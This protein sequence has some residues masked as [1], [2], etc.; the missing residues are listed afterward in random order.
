MNTTRLL[1]L[2]LLA[3]AL[4]TSP[5]LGLG[6]EPPVELSGVE[7]GAAT[8]SVRVI[9]PA[10][11]LESGVPDE[12]VAAEVMRVLPAGGVTTGERG[13]LLTRDKMVGMRYRLDRQA[14][15]SGVVGND[16]GDTSFDLFWPF[17]ANGDDRFM[18]LDLRT[19]VNDQGRGGASAG[20]G[21][22]SYN[23][24]LDRIFGLSGWWDWDN[25]HHRTYRQAGVSFE[26]LGQ[27]FDFRVNGYFPLTTE[28]HTVYDSTDFSNPYFGGFNILVDRTRVF[29]SNYRGVDAEV[30]GPLPVLGR[31]GAR[32]YMGIYHWSSENDRDTT[33]WKAR[34]ETQVTDDVMVGVS[35]SRDTVFGTNTWLNIVLTLPDG[36]PETFFRPQSMRQRLNGLVRRNGRVVV[37]RRRQVDGVPLVQSSG[38]GAGDPIE[39]VWI[40][41]NAAFNG[42]GS[43]ESP[44]NNLEA[45][46]NLPENDMLIVGSG[47]LSGSLT[48]FDDQMLLSEWVLNQQQYVLDTTSGPILLPGVD[49][50][51]TKPTFRNPVGLDGN[52]GG[53]IVTIAGSNTQIGGMIFDG[54]TD[55]ID[56]YANAI[57]TAPGWTIGGFD[58]FDN[59]FDRTRNSVAFTN[60]S[61][62]G[63]AAALGIFERNLL[64]GNGNDSI[65]GFQLTAT[66]GSLLNL[67]VADNTV[68][69]YLGEDLDNDGVLDPGED[70]NGNG[71][72]DAGVA[73]SITA[74]ERAVINAVSIPG[75][76]ADPN[77]PGLVLG[78]TNNVAV[79][80]GTGLLLLSETE[81]VINADVSGNTFNNNF[82]PNTG[83]SITADGDG[84][85][86]YLLNF[87]NN[88]VSNNLGVG[89]RLKATG[90]GL[91]ASVA[92]EDR[93]RNGVL[94]PTE[95]SNGNGLLDI[96]EDLN[97][98][99]ILDGA[100]DVNGNGILDLGFT[101]NTLI[102]N[103]GDGL[104]AMVN[105]GS[106]TNLHIGSA[107]DLLRDDMEFGVLAEPDVNADGFLNHGNGNGLLDAGEDVNGNGVLD[108]GEDD[109]EDRNNNGIRDQ[110]N[111]RFIGALPSE[112]INGDGVLNR[113]NG[114]GL[115]DPSEDTNNNGLLDFGE[116]FDEDVNGNGLLDGPDNVITGNGV[117]LLGG[118]SGIVLMTLPTED[119]NGNGTLELGEDANGNGR[120]DIGGGVIIA[121]LVNTFLDNT[122]V[123]DAAGV[124]TGVNNSGSHLS[125]SSD[126]GSLGT[127]TV[128]LTTITNNSMTGAGLDSITIN[129]N[130]TGSVVIGAINNSTLDNNSRHGI[131]VQ[132]DTGAVSLG[133]VDSSTFNR[134]YNGGDGIHVDSENGVI[135]GVITRSRF[136]GDPVGNLIS[137]DVNGNGVLDTGEDT[138][139]NGRL[140]LGT[141]IG[142]VVRATGGNVSL[143]IGQTDLGNLFDNNIGAGIEYTLIESGHGRV[144]IRDNQIYR[145]FAEVDINS[146][147]VLDVDEDLNNNGRL[148]Q[149]DGI[150]V[151]AIGNLLTGIANPLLD[152]SIIDGNLIG[153]IEASEDINGNGVLD[154][155][156]DVNL[157][158]TLDTVL[159][160][161]GSGIVFDIQEKA[162]VRNFWIGFVDESAEEDSL[163]GNTIVNNGADGIFIERLDDAIID[164]IIIRNNL[165]EANGLAQ[166]FSDRKSV[167]GSGI[168]IAARD[169]GDSL[170]LMDAQFN[171][172][173][174][175]QFNG[176][177][178]LVDG[179]ARLQFDMFRNLVKEN[180]V[181]DLDGANLTA[182]ILTL[183]NFNDATDSRELVGIWQANQIIA[184]TGYGIRFDSTATSLY[185]LVPPDVIANE[186]QILGNLIDGNGLDGIEFN[187]MGRLLI[188]SNDITNNGFNADL[189]G[190]GNDDNGNGID[191]QAVL[192]TATGAVEDQTVEPE[193]A[194]EIQAASKKV[195]LIY[196]N[197][198]LNNALDGL[199]IRHANNPS[200][201]H[202]NNSVY[203]PLHPGHYPLE[204]E[205]RE[206]VF[207]NN[208][209]RG[210]DILNQ[211]GDRIPRPLDFDEAT[212]ET[213]A[214][215]FSP[216]DTL[217]R[218]LNN[219]IFSNDKEGVYVVNTAALSQL[220]SGRTP[221]PPQSDPHDPVRGMANDDADN[222]LLGR[223][224]AVPRL[225]LE[226]HENTIIDN[227]QLLDSDPDP[228]NGGSEITTLNG[229]G[230]VIRVGTADFRLPLAFA[231]SPEEGALLEEHGFFHINQPGGVVAKVTDTEFGSNFGSDVYIESFVSTDTNFDPY[232]ISRL[233]LIFENN[234][235]ESLS[236]TNH[237]AWYPG[238]DNIRANA[239][240][241]PQE[242]DVGGFPTPVYG[243]VVG[244]HTSTLTGGPLSGGNPSQS[245]FDGDHD[246]E[247]RTSIYNGHEIE[248]TAGPNAEIW[249]FISSYNGSN[250]RISVNPSFP[251]VPELGDAF[252]IELSR[253]DWFDVAL[254]TGDP[255][256]DPNAT[257]L[258]NGPA[259][260]VLLD[261]GVLIKFLSGPLDDYIAVVERNFELDNGRSLGDFAPENENPSL[262][263]FMADG[264]PAD[265]RDQQALGRVLSG[266]NSLPDSDEAGL[267]FGT[268]SN[269]TIQ[270]LNSLPRPPRDGD[271][272]LLSALVPGLGETSFRV[273]GAMISGGE[274]TETN[275]FNVHD[276]GFDDKV[277][278]ETGLPIGDELPFEWGLMEDTTS[279]RIRSFFPTLPNLSTVPPVTY[280]DFLP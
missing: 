161:D 174:R 66:D 89:M 71:V 151:R 178:L 49:P 158:G 254:L 50:L 159:G 145:T 229:S 261:R 15:G 45:Y 110:A 192:L 46:N 233:D 35:V 134:I 246:L 270:M 225:V 63:S 5:H 64:R 57:T 85:T 263:H 131:N 267:P 191:I 217:V 119:L 92:N 132:A 244:V 47:D 2:G 77:D 247:H 266:I 102:G 7:G 27:F 96:G 142:V 137:E 180:G 40:D 273:R 23:E 117:F 215:Q 265:L 107:S 12:S 196:R 268:G 223:D 232:P 105:D 31:Y 55:I 155:G 269:Q 220:Q 262:F 22:R 108:A 210:I 202:G 83:V 56:V 206:N 78:I 124:P 219:R 264:T 122:S 58:I 278:L 38:A 164:G 257:P 53:S 86:I 258:R 252:Q 123:R 98:N 139:D 130:N 75:D 67:R 116:D 154:P 24:Q 250:H 106:I 177:R 199:E 88:D 182:G 242:L 152:D 200:S 168:S 9:R 195:V 19:R 216:T 104:V 274:G 218:L 259:T 144:A 72:L 171:K 148:D 16:T 90:G 114:D 33:G 275:A 82:D 8:G 1:I 115:L 240:R 173:Q 277:S 280:K 87:S 170:L 128:N 185:N 138:N 65:A 121:G 165:I 279:D 157:N 183:E 93:N 14:A 43:Y 81:G 243:Y 181:G 160:N 70:A 103:G 133:T 234:V 95:D 52:D 222:Q 230:L 272:F 276:L 62:I 237:G 30:G 188:D 248:F 236:V 42:T 32:G 48:L 221:T 249:R 94:D 211:G 251:S 253:P 189:A 256:E 37:N 100:E 80:N 79:G 179:D 203:T 245:T 125:I 109:N 34:V 17:E 143:E 68:S 208:G 163:T 141:G 113:G 214:G 13:P 84:S 36:R 175:N 156:E 111:E 166:P 186:M 120:L 172:I 112:D 41:P 238:P 91:I 18:F 73:F 184:N 190:L 162:T 140:D 39:L 3:C 204:V 197:N 153:S 76:P 97:G 10:E 136:Q 201:F 135:T 101:G 51:A 21:Y 271:L 74:R 11:E 226:V 54:Q 239:Q 231:A 241:L 212:G 150:L 228:A 149:G 198:V 6:A 147:G 118:G 169:G 126:G 4:L 25:S 26:S 209:G 99:G 61:S 167:F 194:A 255:R 193:L 146:N 187:G 224:N 235:G 69:N 29:E 28:Y 44:L 260:D 176:V 127:G 60:N 213:M 129:S 205:V 207:E 20:I 59:E 227:G